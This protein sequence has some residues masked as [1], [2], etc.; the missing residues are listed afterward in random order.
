MKNKQI[1]ELDFLIQSQ[2]EQ[3]IKGNLTEIGV[4][5]L[6][7][8]RTARKIFSGSSIDC[9]HEWVSSVAYKGANYPNG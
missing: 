9:E 5:Y 8:L 7:G 4:S 1:Q 6:N 2:E 3:E